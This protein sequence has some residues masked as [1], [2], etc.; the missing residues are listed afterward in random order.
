VVHL[1]KN[2]GRVD[3]GN[4]EVTSPPA[5]LGDLVIVG[6]AIGD[7]DRFD[8]ESGVVRAFDARTGELR[9]SW[10]PIPREPDDPGRETWKGEKA[11]RTGAANAWSIISV[12]ATRN[13]VFVPTSCPSPDYY[14]GERLGDNLFANSVV[15][16]EGTTGKLVWHYQVVHHDIWDYDVAS[17]PLLFELERDGQSIPAVAVGTKMGHIFVLHRETGEPLF[18][19]EERPVPASDVPGEVAAPTQPIPAV[20]PALGLHNVTAEELFGTNAEERNGAQERFKSLRFEGLFT[21]PSL[22]GT[23]I[24][25]SNAGGLN[26]SGLTYDPQRQLLVTNVNRIAAVVRLIPRQ[27][28]TRVAG[29][30]FKVELA[31][32][33]GTPYGMAREIFRLPSGL[34]ATPPPWGTLAAINLQTGKL[35]WEVPLG[36]VISPTL[37]PQAAEWGSP[38]LGG[39]TT[40]ASGLVFVAGTLDNHLR[41]FD[42]ETGQELWKAELPAGGNATPMTFQLGPD[43]KQYVVI[44]AGGHG[45]LGTKPGDYVIAFAL[46]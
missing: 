7:N 4:Y 35:Q 8:M 38:S 45:K 27:E 39:A 25:P 2:I 42:V 23:L 20:L 36:S 24:T 30:R 26:W 43:G 46:P 34:P 40:T 31:P 44:C 32:Q 10:D 15:A 16:L 21:P 3:P 9:W 14:G 1:W 28:F 11:T 29:E 33:S 17:Q 37:M 19:V 13:L 12:D 18:P 5:V 41:A 22:Q 6:S